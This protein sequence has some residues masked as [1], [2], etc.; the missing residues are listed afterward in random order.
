MQPPASSLRLGSASKS[1]RNSSEI[2]LFD[3]ATAILVA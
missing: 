3:W 1:L 2:E